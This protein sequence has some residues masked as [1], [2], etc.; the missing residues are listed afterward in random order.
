[1]SMKYYLYISDS[2]LAMLLPQIRATT[3]GTKASTEFSI[4]LKLFSAKR[5]SEQTS[6]MS[7]QEKLDMVVD[8]IRQYGDTGSADQTPETQPE[9]IA[10]SRSIGD[11]ETSMS[12]KLVVAALL[13]IYVTA[14]AQ[15]NLAPICWKSTLR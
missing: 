9:Y 6:E 7:T 12:A 4:N 13:F 14:S 11:R 8:F 2:K 15:C 3:K 10:D 5:S 1:M